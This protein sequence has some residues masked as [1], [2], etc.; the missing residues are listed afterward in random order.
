MEFDS[1]IEFSNAPAVSKGC[2]NDWEAFSKWKPSNCDLDHLLCFFGLL[3]PVPCFILCL[4][5]GRHQITEQNEVL[6]K[7]SSAEIQN[8]KRHTCALIGNE[9]DCSTREF[10]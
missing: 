6:C 9:T 7:A 1:V 8:M 5:L 3:L 10:D 4:Y 2:V